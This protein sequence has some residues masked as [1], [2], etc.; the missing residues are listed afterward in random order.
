MDQEKCFVEVD[1]KVVGQLPVPVR[2]TQWQ[3]SKQKSMKKDVLFHLW[4]C[5]SRKKYL[6]I[7]KKISKKV[8]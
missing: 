3:S 1:Q 8:I 5:V 2:M 4:P 7:L 6:G